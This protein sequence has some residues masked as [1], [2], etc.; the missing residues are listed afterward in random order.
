M[1]DDFAPIDKNNLDTECI[2]QEGLYEKYA[3]RLEQ[4][5]ADYA[6]QETVVEVTWAE[7][8]KKIR[9]RAPEGG[10]AP[11]EG[12]I[13]SL[14]TTHPQYKDEVK[15]LNE[16]RHDVGILQVAVEKTQQRKRE[17][18]NLVRLW[19][20]GYWADPRVPAEARRRLEEE[21]DQRVRD[22]GRMDQLAGNGD[23]DA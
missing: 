20:G 9:G 15:R 22:R 18:D 19:L 8:D 10:K 5:K 6:H 17:L 1:S 16:L 23:D 7:V 14:I 21:S 3:L 2:H 12:A 4:A 13:K 11:T